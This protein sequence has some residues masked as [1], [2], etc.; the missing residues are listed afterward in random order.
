MLSLSGQELKIAVLRVAFQPDSSPATTG[1]GSFV[2]SDT[3]GLECPDW[4]LDPPP[5]GRTYF[6]DHLIAMDN[7]WQRV[8][9][10]AVHVNFTKSD[11]YP[12]NEVDVYQ[13][14]HDMLY[15]HPYLEAYDE[16]EKLFEL[17]RDVIALADP[18]ID[19]S[20]Y[21]T[22]IL[23]HAGMGGDFAFA[24]D[25]T[26]GNIPS[27]YLSQDDFT[28]YGN[29]QTDEGDLDDL[30]IIPESQNFLQ[31][32]ET[33][34][35]FEDAEDPCFYQ[36]ALNGTLAL[37][38][39]FH[40]DLP[41]LYN[42]DTGLSMV[43]GFAL[44]DQGSNNLHGIVPAYPN[45]FTRIKQGWTTVN[46]KQVGDTVSIHVDDAPVKI[47]ISETEYYLVENRQRNILNPNSMTLWIDSSGYDTVS[48]IL[49]TDGVV[50]QVDEQ[51]AGLP[52]NGLNIWHIDEDARFTNENPNGGPFQFVDFVE[53]DG[54]QDM[55]HTT[56]L[57]FADYLETGWWF[58]TWFAGNA[59]WFHLNR[60]EE[61][62]GDSLLYFN[63]STFP[64]TN[65]NSG[66]PS[67]LNIGNISR[68]GSTM[69]FSISSDRLAVKDSISTFMGWAAAPNILWAF[70][71]DSSQI[72]E[73]SFADGKLTSTSSVNVSPADILRIDGD[74]TFQFRYPW[75]F[76]NWASGS[77]F[78]NIETG[79]FH[80]NLGYSH[81]FEIVVGTTPELTLSYFAE[82]D[83][84]Y[85]LVKRIDQ[86]NQT[87]GGTALLGS[88]VAR[89]QTTSG[90]QVF[91]ASL[92]PDPTPAGVTPF[93]DPG[94]VFMILPEALDVISWSNGDN[95]IKI[96]HLP[97][98]EVA[99]I[100]AEK[101][102]HIV[103]LDVDLDGYYEIALF[104]ENSINI[105]NQVG[106][107]HN[108]NPFRVE[109]Y[110]GNPIAGSTIE[111]EPS[112]FL[113]HA[114]GYSIYDYSGGLLDSGVLPSFIGAI[115]NSLSVSLGLSL[116]LSGQELLYF[117]YDP[118]IDGIAFWSDPQGSRAGDRVAL[119]PVVTTQSNPAIQ[120]NSVYNYPN[121]IKGNTTT[122][123]A[124]LG[125]VETWSIEIFSMNGAQIARVEQDVLQTNS[126]NEWL[127]D[128]SG[129]SN[130]VYLAQIVAGNDSEIIKIAVIR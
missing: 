123:R 34:S 57:L 119:T 109:S 28:A 62:V 56:Q 125:D 66:T 59:G 36:V 104:Y 97:T 23:A 113:R 18:D 16:T 82:K 48:V 98:D 103:P 3:F 129:V 100:D 8:S 86:L 84:E 106:I 65:T 121:P 105:V 14:P 72:V 6:N 128:A 27:A 49:S 45:P 29:L 2:L 116:I 95:A 5:H 93:R 80:T 20:E 114:E 44:M 12:I 52:G 91:Y 21:T 7:Y 122:I 42:T 118:S 87:I 90:I 53:A 15:Y 75:V 99:F 74:S 110:F 130:G 51:H 102:L 33:R 79:V 126:Y 76:P 58:D 112:I 117:N 32:Q 22:V 61:V 92:T 41:P 46:E 115:E 89:F 120:S 30:I 124:W 69:S 55:G 37:M 127:W 43:G 108:G 47:S 88:P 78:R 26:P 83:E 101:P 77:R 24:L 54:A 10:G 4:T 67:H 71:S 19:F 81:P 13:L 1:D 85:Y 70:N 50:L 111:G 40:L 35:L 73:T 94:G 39:G 9:N 38:I 17:S 68:N 60:Y 11:V 107:S 31:Y 96:S 64:S 63:S 25:P